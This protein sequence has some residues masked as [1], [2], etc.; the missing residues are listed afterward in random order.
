MKD[1]LQIKPVEQHELKVLLSADSFCVNDYSESDPTK[2]R[3]EL[4]GLKE[5]WELAL[6]P[7]ERLL[8]YGWNSKQSMPHQ[9]L[10]TKRLK[11]IYDNTERAESK[12]V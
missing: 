12:L 10:L 8:V 5:A 1:K 7:G 3:R 2:M 4:P 9:V 11:E 6:R